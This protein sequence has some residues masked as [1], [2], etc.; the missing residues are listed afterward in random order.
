MIWQSLLHKKKQPKNI[1]SKHS[2]NNW[3]NLFIPHSATQE[4]WLK[5]KKQKTSNKQDAVIPKPKRKK[6]EQK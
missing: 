1:K 5:E 4:K 2:E 6:K 3:R